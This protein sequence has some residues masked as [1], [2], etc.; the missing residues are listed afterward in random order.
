MRA[1]DLWSLAV[2]NLWSPAVV[3]R[4]KGC[5]E[6]RGFIVSTHTAGESAE[7]DIF[8]VNGDGSH[9]IV[10]QTIPCSK[11]SPLTRMPVICAHTPVGTPNPD[12]LVTYGQATNVITGK[13]IALGESLPLLSVQVAAVQSS[14]RSDPQ[15]PTI[16]GDSRDLPFG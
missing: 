16:R 9:I 15:I 11:D 14:P 12:F 8:A 4:L 1:Y 5:P 6:V 3:L 13:A 10:R 7:P 2:S